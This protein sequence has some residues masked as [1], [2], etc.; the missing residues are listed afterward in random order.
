[1]HFGCQT[2]RAARGDL[3]PFVPIRVFGRGY[4]LIRALVMVAPESAA[5]IVTEPVAAARRFCNRWFYRSR[6]SAITG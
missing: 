2:T 5:L 6:L 4:T 3:R 1:M